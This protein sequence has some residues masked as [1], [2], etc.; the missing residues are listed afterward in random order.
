M[1]Q[2]IELAVTQQHS[3]GRITLA[4]MHTCDGVIVYRH[5]KSL[6]AGELEVLDNELARALYHAG[7]TQVNRAT[8]QMRLF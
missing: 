3:G 7:T 6:P 5:R 2:R 8:E 1:M 4:I